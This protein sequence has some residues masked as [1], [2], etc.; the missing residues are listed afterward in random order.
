MDGESLPAKSTKGIEKCGLNNLTTC[1]IRSSFNVGLKAAR[2]FSWTSAVNILTVLFLHTQQS[3][4]KE[5]LCNT[6]LLY[7][8]S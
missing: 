6:R 2:A 3:T 1:A 7:Y 8:R 4:A 5:F